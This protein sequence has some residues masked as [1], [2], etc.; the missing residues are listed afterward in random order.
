MVNGSAT[1]RSY[2]SCHICAAAC[3]RLKNPDRSAGRAGAAELLNQQDTIRMELNI[4]AII[5]RLPHRYPMLLIDRVLEIVPG[6]YTVDIK[7]VP[8]YEPFFDG[9]YPHHPVM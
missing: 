1:P 8:I 9:H 6:K 2:S 5:E 7:N 3:G 4:K